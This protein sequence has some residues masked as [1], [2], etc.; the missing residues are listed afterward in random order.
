MKKG[1]YILSCFLL[2][3]HAIAQTITTTGMTFSPDTL[4][5]NVGDTINF[6][7]GSTHNAIEVDE[8]TYNADGT[9]SNGGFN[10]GFGATGTFIPSLAQTYYYVCTPHVSLGM[11][12]VIIASPPPCIKSLTQGLNGF[13]PNPVYNA[14]VWSYETLTLTNTSN[15]SI[16]VRPEFEIS[17]DSLPIDTSNFDLKFLSPLGFWGDLMYTIN[18]NGNAVGYGSMGGDTTGVPIDA[19]V[20]QTIDVR[21]RFK[22]SASYGKYTA[23]WKT[24]EVDSIGNIIQTLASGDSVE[25]SYIDCSVFEIDSTYSSDISCFDANDGTASIVSL[26][27]GSGNYDYNWSNGDT[28]NTATNLNAGNHSCVV[29]DMFA[30]QCSDT[31][32]FTISEPAEISVSSTQNNVTCNGGSDGSATIS[33]NG[34]ILPFSINAFGYNL[35]LPPP[36]NFFTT[37]ASI[38]AGIYPYTGT[39]ATGCVIHDTIIITEPATITSVATTTSPS[40][41][42]ACDGSITIS[43]VSGGSGSY[44]YLWTGPSGYNSTSSS[45]SGL[46]EGTYQLTITDDNTCTGIQTIVINDPACNIL[47][48][49]IIT[50]PLCCGYPGNFDFNIAGG[51]PPYQIEILEFG[52]N[53]L[54]YSESNAGTPGSVINLNQGN[55]YMTVLGDLGCFEQIDGIGIIEPPCIS[56]SI[57]TDSVSCNGGSDGQATAIITGGTTPYVT[58]DWSNNPSNNTPV[59]S[60]LSAN[61]ASTLTVTDANG[62]IEDGFYIVSEPNQLVTTFNISNILCYGDTNGTISAIVSGGTMPYTYFWS[63]TGDTTQS[64]SLI[65]LGSYTCVI[66]DANGC[67]ETTVITNLSEPAELTSSY[68]QTNVSCYGANDGSAIVDFFGGTTGDTLGDTNYILGW[69]GNTVVLPYPLTQFNTNTLPPPFNAIPPGIYP[70]S[71]TDLNGCTIY[72]TITITEPDSLSGIL[73]ADTICCPGSAGGIATATING[74]TGPYTYLWDDPSLQTTAIAT[75]LVAGTYSCTVIDDNA[76]QWTDSITVYEYQLISTSYTATNILCNGESSGC[77]NTTTTG[78]TGNYTYLWSNGDTT[79]NI[80]NLTAGSYTC[81]ITDG[82]GCTEWITINISEPNILNATIDSTFNITTYGG[83]DG[84]IYT[85]FNG[86][87]GQL[88]INWSSNNGFSSTS[89]DITNLPAGLYYLAITDSNACTLLDTIELTQ[90]SSLWM[91]L[92]LA[93]NASCFDSC[94]GILQV[95]ANGGDSSYTY[96]WQGPNGYTS[97]NS[98]LTNLCYGEYILTVDDGL[99]TI[100]DT[101][102]IF[103]PLAITSTLSFDTI[104]CHDGLT[105]AEINVWGGTQPFIYNWSN[106]DNNYITNIGSGSH[107]IIVID[108]N[109]CSIS[110]SFSLTNPQPIISTSSSTNVACFGGNNGSASINIVS[111]GTPPYSFSNDNGITYQVSNTFNNLSSGNYSLLISDSNSCFSYIPIEITEPAE[112]SSVTSTVDASCFGSCDGNILVTVSGGTSPYSYLWSNG[113]T[114]QNASSLCAGFYNVTITDS[115]NCLAINSG[116]INEPNAILINISIDGN[117]LVA[118]SGFSYYQWYFANGTPVIGATSESFNPDSMGEYYVVVSDGNCEETSYTINYNINDINDINKQ[119]RIYPNPTNGLITI[120]TDNVIQNITI[121]NL[122]GNQLLKVEKNNLDI[123]STKID[124]SNFVKGIYIIQ[125]KQNDQTMNYRIALQ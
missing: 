27:N 93:I 24:K 120:D 85:S 91:N 104:T 48:D 112:I 17:H 75:G 117:S 23:I 68:T 95:T 18:A 36:Y 86:G 98:N 64:T 44:S 1:L 76:C 72:D 5:V 33:F 103:Q 40:L 13:T 52:T 107:S 106:L 32:E 67:N 65:G 29:I 122:I 4:Y 58:Y 7:L 41:N 66:T 125:I 9:T 37:P 88:N 79:A 114:T 59:N 109:G 110:D 16:R 56:V 73:T 124:L 108:A 31:I 116:I 47:I 51:Q 81:M 113:Q 62:C 102:N 14:W 15:C 49:T 38:P 43:S 34:G 105:Q 28:T 97:S 3:N 12:G 61:I 60:G 25:L 78:G 54:V 46:C 57:D 111:G 50:Q 35:T 74:G 22:P 21:V 55:Y 94:N 26:T 118:T 121:I 83:N 70:Y 100:S 80:C 2:A 39:D 71:V 20:M 53:T 11:K 90:P 19:G 123:T 30:Q 92:D 89:G 101:F 8:T 10:F 42:G 99:T 45:I 77:I 115:N 69:A 82:C 87:T 63:I 84:A 96:S 119:I 6:V